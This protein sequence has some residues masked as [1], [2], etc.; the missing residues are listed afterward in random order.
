MVDALARALSRQLPSDPPGRAALVAE[1][2]QDIDTLG[3]DLTRTASKVVAGI[4]LPGR[5]HATLRGP[6][7]KARAAVIRG[8]G[9]KD[10]QTV[11]RLLAEVADDLALGASQ[12]QRPT[13]LSRGEARL[14]ASATVLT[15]GARSLRRLGTLGRELSHII[16]IDLARVA[17]ARE[18]KDFM[19]AE[20]AA[21]D[22]AARLRQPDPSFAASGHSGRGGGEAGGGRGT[23]GDEPSDPDDVQQAF[24]EAARAGRPRLSSAGMAKA[25]AIDKP[26]PSANSKLHAKRSGRGKAT[27][28]TSRKT[29]FLQRGTPMCPRPTPT[30]APRNSDGGSFTAWGNRRAEDSKTPYVVMPR[31]CCDEEAS[32]RLR[33]TALDDPRVRRLRGAALETIRFSALS[34]SQRGRKARRGGSCVTLVGQEAI[35]T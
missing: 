9:F 16:A 31:D 22:L 10:S 25:D 7:E 30:R 12:M 14:D 5:L 26:R 34:D 2:L 18:A 35:T 28:E 3:Q 13:E 27:L 8:L 24:Q 15:G 21:R 33:A 1:E 32:C 6:L 20:L 17:R 11:A 19:H 29:G 23:A 4:R